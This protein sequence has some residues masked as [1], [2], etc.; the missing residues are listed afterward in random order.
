MKGPVPKNPR[1]RRRQNKIAGA[2]VL[3]LLPP[4]KVKV[5]PLPRRS[6]RRPQWT[7]RTREWW[8]EIWASP[9]TS[10][11]LESDRGGLLILA[12]LLDLFWRADSTTAKV[13]L[14]GEIRLQ[15]QRYGLSPLDRR[16]LQW[17]VARGEEAQ[18]R[19]ERRQSQPEAGRDARLTLIEE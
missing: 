15:G 12:D 16:R 19:T 8:R 14:A 17:E 11:W 7:E 3:Q 1:T 5:P 10:E 18:R 4:E 6:D 9:M 13:Q 2:S